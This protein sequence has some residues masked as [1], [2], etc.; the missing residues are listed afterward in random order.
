MS[1]S[2]QDWYQRGVDAMQ[3]GDFRA[4]V[5]AYQYAL[6]LSA[7]NPNVLFALAVAFQNTHQNEE[8]I[9]AYLRALDSDRQ[10][11]DAANNAAILCSMIGQTERAVDIYKNFLLYNRNHLDATVNLGNFLMQLRRPKE[12]IDYYHDILIMR[13]GHAVITPS[14]AAVMA[15]IGD[16]KMATSHLLK[17][18]KNCPEDADAHFTTGYF[19][20]SYRHDYDAAAEHYRAAVAL[21]PDDLSYR[22]SYINSLQCAGRYEEAVEQAKLV[23]VE[24]FTLL[25]MRVT[26]LPAYH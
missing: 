25:A 14:I 1:D 26:P 17:W 13:P 23:E 24:G 16:G 15:M 8:A 12:A 10:F 3:G 11:F 4:A 19:L 2:F 6:T 22:R 5:E 7:N 18:V 9:D 20:F 21:Q